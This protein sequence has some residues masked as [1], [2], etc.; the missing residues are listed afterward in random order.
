MQFIKDDYLPR[1]FFEGTN[2]FKPIKEE[3][4]WIEEVGFTISLMGNELGD[5]YLVVLYGSDAVSPEKEGIYY[6]DDE[7]EA[8]QFY[9]KTL[10]EHYQSGDD[11]EFKDG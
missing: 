1:M 11:Y 4:H 3:S 9:Q 10:R 7:K 2:D 5:R 8:E 6:F